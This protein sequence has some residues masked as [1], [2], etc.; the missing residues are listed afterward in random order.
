MTSEPTATQ[1]AEWMLE[2]LKRQGK[3]HED[4]LAYEIE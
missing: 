1:V 2:E 3:L 4:T